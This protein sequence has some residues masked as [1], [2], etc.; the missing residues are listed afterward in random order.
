MQ[1]SSYAETILRRLGKISHH[2]LIRRSSFAILK[3]HA[4]AGWSMEVKS[5]EHVKALE[6]S[7]GTLDGKLGDG[8]MDEETGRQEQCGWR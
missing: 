5:V 4:E 8:V 1:M 7:Q 3:K 6:C 2:R